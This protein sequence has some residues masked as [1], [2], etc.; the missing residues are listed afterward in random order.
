MIKKK[1]FQI[2][3]LSQNR[4]FETPYGEEQFIISLGTWL[5]KQDH[6][7]VLMGSTFS[8]IQTKYLSKNYN[9]EK[10][11]EE[12]KK[13]RAV[14]PPWSIYMSSRL[15]LSL[16]WFMK[17]LIINIKTP[18]N[19]IHAQ[20]TGYSGLAGIFAAK[21]L[22]IPVVLSSHGIRHKTIEPKIRGIFSGILRNL[23]YKLDIFTIK[24]ANSVIAVSPSVKN[25]YEKI[26]KKKLDVIPISIKTKDFEFSVKNR[27]SLRNELGI[28]K[29]AKVIGFVGRLSPEKNILTLLMA[30]NE[31]VKESPLTLILTGTGFSEPQLKEYVKNQKI[32][33]KVIFCGLRRDIPRILSAI[34]IFVLPSFT[35]GLP[36]ALLEAMASGRAIIC[37]NIPAHKPL[38]EHNKDGLFFD[39]HESE[40]LKQAILKLSSNNSLRE[41]FGNNAK[42]KVMEYDEEK[43]YP[44]IMEHYTKLLNKKTKE[45]IQK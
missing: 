14:F 38:I 21:I 6:K 11:K 24:N 1:I 28:E 44:K 26:I 16:L 12:N 3:I 25:Y 9:E 4:I 40:Q 8:G 41:T 23:E 5:T 10:K 45:N 34:D 18:I 22:G 33:D 36:T 31:A 19:L 29:N 42:I 27:N 2:C 20:D 7:V 17:I 37:S 39:P 32:N 43:V 35:E 13:I 30:F 15:F